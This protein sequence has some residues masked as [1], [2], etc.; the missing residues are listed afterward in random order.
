MSSNLIMAMELQLAS[1]AVSVISLLTSSSSATCPLGS[2]VDCMFVVACSCQVSPCF[3]SDFCSYRVD[4]HPYE[5]LHRQQPGEAFDAF[6][7]HPILSA[8][9]CCGARVAFWRDMANR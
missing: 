1:F 5:A 4:Q 8:G 9:W 2:S 3:D 7:I 6:Q